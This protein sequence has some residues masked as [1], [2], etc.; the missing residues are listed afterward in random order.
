MQEQTE[1]P[2]P[3][4]IKAFLVV[5]AIF[6]PI[7]GWN[8]ITFQTP[9]VAAKIDVVM[10][11]PAKFM[12][13]EHARAAIL[14]AVS[15]HPDFFLELALHYEWERRPKDAIA[16]AR[17]ALARAQSGRQAREAREIIARMEAAAEQTAAQP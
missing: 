9:E 15:N 4:I 12:G 13:N 2:E 7:V 8:V 11:W 1:K 17:R 16:M 5:G 6:A 14:S 10:K 3:S